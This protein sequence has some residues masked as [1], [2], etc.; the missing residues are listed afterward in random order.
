[1]TVILVL[2]LCRRNLDEEETI[3]ESLEK[4]KLIA[5]LYGGLSVLLNGKSEQLAI[6]LKWQDNF[7]E[8]K[9][10]FINRFQGQFPYWDYIEIF[11]AAKII[12]R[13]NQ[14]LFEELVLKD[15]TRLVL[16]NLTSGHFHCEASE[17]LI[18]NLI[19]GKNELDRNI[20]FFLL[21]S[22]LN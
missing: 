2:A 22:K 6:K 4:N 19:N 9:Y 21:V 14:N 20:G 7:F 17:K 15:K 8:N 3:Y 1:M 11:I 10:E 5:S 18:F 13:D 16:L 12:H